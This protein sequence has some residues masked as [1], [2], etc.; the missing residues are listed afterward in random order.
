[1]T[2]MVTLIV[3]YCIPCLQKSNQ[4]PPSKGKPTHRE[5]LIYPM[6]RIYIDTV[7]P[8]TP[9]RINGKIMKHIF[10]ILD[11]FTR[12]LIAIPIPDLEASTLLNTFVEGF[13][14][15]FGIP[16]VDRF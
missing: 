13:C 4:V 9:S 10:T 3:D 16:E 14:L 2:D 12:Y 11:G 5:L 15:K 7:G 6:Q 8:L 1:M